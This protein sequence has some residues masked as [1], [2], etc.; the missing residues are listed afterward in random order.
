MKKKMLMKIQSFIFIWI[1]IPLNFLVIPVYFILQQLKL[2]NSLFI[3]ALFFTACALPFTISIL[4]ESLINQ[5]EEALKSAEL[6]GAN[7]FQILLMVI[8][9]ESIKSIITV[10]LNSFIVSWTTFIV[11]FILINSS[12]KQP[13]STAFYEQ[14]SASYGTNLGELAAFAIL[15]TLPIWIIY[16]ISYTVLNKR[17]FFKNIVQID[18]SKFES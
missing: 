2:L 5:P 8:L 11:P 4:T 16:F 1:G 12:D 6:D 7:F 17:L 10:G 14:F 15:Y 18:V 9:P 13:V 3:T